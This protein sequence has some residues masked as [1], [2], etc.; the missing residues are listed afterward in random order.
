MGRQTR[1]DDARRVAV[2]IPA[3][4]AGRGTPPRAEGRPPP[5]VRS[6]YLAAAHPESVRAASG[7]CVH[8][9]KPRGLCPVLLC[10]TRGVGEKVM[11]ITFSERQVGDDLAE[12]FR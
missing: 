5:A 10:S 7:Q 6:A 4:H 2:R 3:G 9:T 11:R 12:F 1:S 8:A